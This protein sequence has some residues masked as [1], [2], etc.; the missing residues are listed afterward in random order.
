VREA[1]R[2]GVGGG[3]PT[4]S[5]SRGRRRGGCGEGDRAD[6]M[7]PRVNERGRANERVGTNR[8]DPID[9]ER[10]VGNEQARPS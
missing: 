10:K 3:L 7:G 9:R 4:Q 8:A 1:S 5:T 2:G 6:G